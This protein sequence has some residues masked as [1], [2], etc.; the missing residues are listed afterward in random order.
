MHAR[1][2]IVQGLRDACCTEECI[3]AFMRAYDEGRPKDGLKAIEGFRRKTLEELHEQQ[4][5]ID[6]LDYLTYEM[7]RLAAR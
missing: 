4:R 6:C 1:C 3:E 2:D 5:R 7:N